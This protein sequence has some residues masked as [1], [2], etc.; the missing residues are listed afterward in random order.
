M[1]G[2]PLLIIGIILLLICL[3]LAQ[4]RDDCPNLNE[5]WVLS[6]RGWV[7]VEASG[8]GGGY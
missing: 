3:Y 1:R 8:K 7:C 4:H 5:V 6:D 2:L